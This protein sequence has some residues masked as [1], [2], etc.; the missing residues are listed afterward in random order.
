MMT[1]PLILAKEVKIMEITT[2]RFS[3]L[4]SPR[5]PSWDPKGTIS[6]VGLSSLSGL[7]CF[8]MI[9][10]SYEY[11][12]Q[13]WKIIIK[14]NNLYQIIEKLTPAE[15]AF[16]LT[17]PGVPPLGSA[18]AGTYRFLSYLFC[19]FVPTDLF[20][21][22]HYFVPID[23]HLIYS[24]ILYLQIDHVFKNIHNNC[25]RILIR[26]LWHLV[27]YIWW[28]YLL[29]WTGNVIGTFN[30]ELPL[31]INSGWQKVVQQK[32]KHIVEQQGKHLVAQ[33]TKGQRTFGALTGRSGVAGLDREPKKRSGFSGEIF[34]D[35][36]FAR[37]LATAPCKNMV[38]RENKMVVFPLIWDCLHCSLSICSFQVG[39]D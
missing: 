28:K 2:S 26:C 13:N 9:K 38:K 33:I 3:P 27:C 23:F 10:N 5:P 14:S 16:F 17:G 32:R 30:Y 19:Y 35:S 18:G 29:C 7:T 12:F 24:V 21:I 39:A 36:N 1:P 6:R 15:F 4:P 8:Y 34:C 37:P 11:I 22:S 25:Y 31:N 20:L